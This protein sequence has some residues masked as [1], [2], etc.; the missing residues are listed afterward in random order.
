MFKSIRKAFDKKKQK[1]QAEPKLAAGEGIRQLAA[2]LPEAGDP[3]PTP[4]RRSPARPPAAAAQEPAADPPE[5]G[6]SE[7]PVEARRNLIDEALRIRD[8]KAKDLE[9]NIPARDRIK[10]RQL[11]EKMMLGDDPEETLGTP[12]D[13]P[14]PRRQTRH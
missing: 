12:S 1:K 4:A 6:P 11:A 7:N 9:E 10:L 14:G 2:A 5:A 13:R 8:E 3:P